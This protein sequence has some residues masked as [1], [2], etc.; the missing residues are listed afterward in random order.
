MPMY[1]QNGALYGTRERRSRSYGIGGPLARRDVRQA[2]AAG[3]FKRSV[4]GASDDARIAGIGI[5]RL[6]AFVDFLA[7]QTDVGGGG[8]IVLL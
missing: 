5:P 2:V 7:G 6:T 3:G 1:V 8:S 4:D